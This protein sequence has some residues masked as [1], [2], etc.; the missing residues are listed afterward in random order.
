MTTVRFH[1]MYTDYSADPDTGDIFMKDGQKK[2][3]GKWFNFYHDKKTRSILW[4][5]FVFECVYDLMP[6]KVRIETI[7]NGLKGV[8]AMR[9]IDSDSKEEVHFQALN[10]A[11][12]NTIE[13]RR[14][15]KLSTGEWRS[16]PKHAEFM[17]SKAGEVF[18]LRRNAVSKAKPAKHSNQ[19]RH[20]MNNEIIE[21]MTFVYECW[22]GLL[23]DFQYVT[24]RNEQT[25]DFRLDNVVLKQIPNHCGLDVAKLNLDEIVAHPTLTEYG[26]NG[27]G[28][29]FN[30]LTKYEFKMKPNRIGYIFLSTKIQMMAHIFVFE[31]FHQRIVQDGQEIDHIN[32]V[33]H[34]N[35]IENLQMLTSEQHKKK[36]AMF[37]RSLK[38]SV[39]KKQMISARQVM[40][41]LK[42]PGGDIQWQKT[43]DSAAAAAVALGDSFKELS[44]N[45]AVS[46]KKSYRGFYWSRPAD[47]DLADEKWTDLTMVGFPTMKVSNKGRVVTTYGKT[48]GS[49][50][51][52][53]YMTVFT[54][55]RV[56]VLVCT[57]FHGPA[58]SDMTNPTVD[59]INQIRYDNDE[60]NLR[61]ADRETQRNNQSNSA[62]VQSFLLDEPNVVL[63]KFASSKAAERA[64]G[65]RSNSIWL[66]CKNKRNYAGKLHGKKIGWR[67]QSPTE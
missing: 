65:V 1:P 60:G 33:K 62:C 42:S 66:C 32:Q 26:A 64:T 34:A 14:Q 59:H 24:P 5:R 61:W 52:D 37:Q 12:S 22:N 21:Q 51:P 11:C 54:N 45:A 36:T 35:H 27:Y 13:I 10:G 44:I 46:S 20:R 57:A 2:Q 53:D 25:S 19:I 16:H 47:E 39:P 7:P 55:V 63:G 40:Q 50:S 38:T 49:R 23:Q 8:H 43:Y 30:I 4:D 17:A 41:T 9:A 48:F 3:K 6:E 56:H 29:V 15:T 67:Y 58:P 31:C 18:N 28:Q